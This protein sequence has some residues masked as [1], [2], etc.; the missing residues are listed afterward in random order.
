MLKLLYRNKLDQ[1]LDLPQQRLREFCRNFCFALK[2]QT[3]LLLR[4]GES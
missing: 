1:P 4:C 2:L 3:K